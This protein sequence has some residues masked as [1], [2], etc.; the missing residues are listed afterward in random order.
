M[1]KKKLTKI[2]G[3]KKSVFDEIL[4][5]QEANPKEITVQEAR[6]IPVAK[7]G[8]E[9]ALTSV[10]LSTLRLV[11][12]FREMFFSKIGI[13]QKTGKYYTFTEVNF[14]QYGEKDARPDGLILQVSGGT[15]KNAILF[16]MKNKNNS[17][18]LPQIET[19]LNI[20]KEFKI[21][22]IITISNEFVSK[23]TQSPLA[24]KKIPKGIEL[25]HFSWSHILTM[26][27]ILLFKNNTNIED[28]DQVEIMKEVVLYLEHE[29]SGVCGFSQMKKGWKE[30]ITKLD[31][32]P[33]INRNDEDILNAV[34]SWQQE[35]KDMALI[36]SRKLGL[37]VKTGS[38]KYKNNLQQ[39]INEDVVNLINKKELVSTFKINGIVS[40]LIIRV[41]FDTK[42]VRMEVR[43]NVTQDKKT[44]KGQLGWFEKQ[45]LKA[46]KFGE[47][48]FTE[49]SNDLHIEIN[50]KHAKD[51][52]HN[53]W[54]DFENFYEELKF[55]KGI[56]DF[57]IILNK[58]FGRKFISPKIF[59]ET[60]EKMIIDFYKVIVQ[61]LKNWEKPTPK[62]T[63]T[64]E[65]EN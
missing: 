53:T 62:I 65:E 48:K 42:Y 58:K 6:L 50:V 34:T 44:I 31:T 49:L 46:K 64:V 51:L 39:R 14:S 61:H 2:E 40:D 10:F 20:A 21:S 4:V 63:D 26:A 7:Q 3:L 5:D 30:A 36:L 52:A 35:E 47:E 8:S 17:L 19:Y 54:D 23:P 18:D 29:I 33:K 28:E 15:I 9:I 38:K 22:K 55:I 16:E 11:K 37:F 1:A 59:V 24:L 32:N 45:I 27:H 57:R 60:I 13:S 43:T 41:A 25:Y 56:N 12:E